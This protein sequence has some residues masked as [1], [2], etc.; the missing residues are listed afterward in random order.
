MSGL[1]PQA[2]TEFY[3]HLHN[4]CVTT[5]DLARR[6]GVSGGAVRRL[7]TGHRRRE[8]PLWKNLQT[9]LTAS[10][11]ILLAEVEQSSTWNTRRRP[12]MPAAA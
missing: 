11:R 2:L 3:W 5:E 10:E 7:I 12:K 1:K 4:R 9:I 8:G 6:L